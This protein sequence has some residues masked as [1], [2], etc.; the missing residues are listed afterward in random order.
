MNARGTY[1]RQL[2]RRA[3]LRAA[4]AGAVAA[5]GLSA[6]AACDSGS[7]QDVTDPDKVS[8]SVTMW[9]YPIDPTNEKAWWPSRIREFTKKYRKVD[10]NVVVQP[11]ADRDTQLTT[12]IAGNKAPDV[13]YLI[14]DQLPQYAANGSLA[15]VTDV[16]AGDRSDFRSDAL[17]ALTSNGTLYGVPLLMGGSGSLVNTKLLKAA[18]ISRLPT[19]WDDILADAPKLK[20]KGY[21]VTEY[22]GDQAQTLNLTFYPFLWQA[23]GDVLSKDQKHAAFN[24]SAGV[25]ALTFIKKLV[26]N[27]YVPKDAITTTP[28]TEEDPVAHGKVALVTEMGVA[29]LSADAGVNLADWTVAPPLKK[30]RSIGYGVVGGLSVMSSSKDMAAAK[31]WVKWLTSPGQM[32][33]FD[34]DRKYY[35]PRKSNGAL[36]GNN[37]LLGAQEKYLDR[38]IGGVINPKARQL[39]DLIKPE[40]QAALLDKKSPK[41]ALDSAASQVNDLLARG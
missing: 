1:R 35:S 30:V 17:A 9:I 39:M 29:D 27:G 4:G 25:A 37:R 21:Y 8:G 6:T 15:D 2:S 13:V 14:P 40:I 36:F 32:K 5:T 18:G 16:I 20:A 24:S 10:V 19:T 41:Q 7:G 11:W 22:V 33:A 28:P 31:A 38:I 23:G 12:A 3:L 26:D 34:I